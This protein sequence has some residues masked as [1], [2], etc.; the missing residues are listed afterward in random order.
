M[1]YRVGEE[2]DLQCHGTNADRK[3]TPR[4]RHPRDLWT[5]TLLAVGVAQFSVAGRQVRRD[6]RNDNVLRSLTLV[7]KQAG[8]HIKFA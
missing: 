2:S 1:R 4:E 5:Q 3:T 8:R 7:R 6:L